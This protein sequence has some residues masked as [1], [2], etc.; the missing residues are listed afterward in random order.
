[1]SIV[2][3]CD[4]RF[5]L[6]SIDPASVMY[7]EDYKLLK[8]L[9]EG[10]HASVKEDPES[11]KKIWGIA[12]ILRAHFGDRAYVEVEKPVHV[13]VGYIVHAIRS[14]ATPVEVRYE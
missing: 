8:D 9:A 2:L 11:L 5:P 13:G 4:R 3:S 1:M 6:L 10:L 7:E 14:S 12:S